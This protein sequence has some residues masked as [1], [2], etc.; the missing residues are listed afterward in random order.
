MRGVAVALWLC[1]CGRVS[2]EDQPPGVPEL[3]VYGAPR[4]ITELNA[5]GFRDDDP[6]ATGDL[7][8]LYFNSDR[9]GGPGL[10]DMYVSRR[11]RT[12]DPWGPPALVA[13]LSTA[14][15]ESNPDVSFDGLT[16]Y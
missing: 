10:Q 12:T 6:S 2:F 5:V 15:D 4:P 13:E 9:P 11:A 16:M 3:P 1:A 7:L 8:E 14:D